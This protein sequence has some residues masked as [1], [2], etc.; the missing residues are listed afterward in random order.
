MEKVD[1]TGRI[2]VLFRIIPFITYITIML[3]IAMI[4]IWIV[5]SIK[6]SRWART[7]AI[8]LTVLVVIAVLLLFTPYL[9]G[10]RSG[11]QIPINY[12]F[13]IKSPVDGKE[14]FR[15]YRDREKDK[16]D[17]DKEKE[18]EEKKSEKKSG[19]DRDIYRPSV[20]FVNGLAVI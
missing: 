5:F 11:K 19:L 17:Y 8:I 15:D 18:I 14:K 6:K 10:A 13:G 9:I 12:F 2:L 16:G 3:L 1:S 4:A 20:D 7:L